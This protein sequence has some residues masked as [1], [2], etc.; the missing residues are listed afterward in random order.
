MTR[1]DELQ[2]A[3]P[4]VPREII[5]K[6]ET[7][8]KGINDSPALDEVGQWSR[9]GGLGTYQSYDR[10][11]TLIELAEKKPGTMKPGYVKRL[12][13]FH[14]R[15]GM[16]VRI[17]RD[18]SSPYRIGKLES[19]Q[20]ALF[21]G[22]DKVENIYFPHKPWPFTEEN[23]P[24]TS[25]GPPI[26]SLLNLRSPNCFMISPVR[27]CE[28]F[29]TGEE[30]KFCNYNATQEDARSVKTTLPI[31]LTPHRCLTFA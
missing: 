5:I 14:M 23:E 26:T 7:L 10:G 27:H 13:S 25:K 30:C 24:L 29:T 12:G 15:N 16:G 22:D 31:H 21:E 6:F 1:V 19:G 28:Y 11:I 2:T 4:G 3:Y 20:F 18:F 17:D 8:T 9:S